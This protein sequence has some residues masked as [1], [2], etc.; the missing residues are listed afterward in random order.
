MISHALHITDVSL[1]PMRYCT[2]LKCNLNATDLT[3]GWHDQNIFLDFGGYS[4][5]RL[6]SACKVNPNVSAGLPRWEMQEKK[7]YKC[8]ASASYHWGAL[9]VWRHSSGSSHKACDSH[10][11]QQGTGTHI[12]CFAAVEAHWTHTVCTEISQGFWTTAGLSLV[13]VL[14]FWYKGQRELWC[15]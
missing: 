10:S 1:L 9:C 14:A 5:T 13:Q 3:S 7:Q 8:S 6:P 12:S 4:K 11:T 15:L 2:K